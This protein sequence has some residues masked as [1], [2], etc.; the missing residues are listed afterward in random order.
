MQGV[1]A[2]NTKDKMESA[3]EQMQSKLQAMEVQ[4]LENDSHLKEKRVF[5]VVVVG[6]AGVGKSSVIYR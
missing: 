1:E 4:Q 2:Q 6:D 3:F 5:K